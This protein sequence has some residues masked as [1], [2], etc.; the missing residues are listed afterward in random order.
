MT[1]LRHIESSDYYQGNHKENTNNFKTD[2]EN[3]KCLVPDC[4]QTHKNKGIKGSQNLGLFKKF[5]EMNISD[6]RAQVVATKSF[7]NCLTPDCASKNCKSKSTCKHCKKTH[8]SLICSESKEN[9]KG[10]NTKKDKEKKP[11]QKE[12]EGESEVH[13][14][15]TENV[16]DDIEE[17][18]VSNMGRVYELSTSE[19][20]FMSQQD[21][22]SMN[23][24]C[25]G[26]VKVR[27]TITKEIVQTMMDI[28]SS[29]S[30]I[31]VSHAKKLGAKQVGV[32]NGL[33]F[34]LLLF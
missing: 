17:I 5:K 30:W 23:L 11:N 27:G 3:R 14:T 22:V 20:F 31:V 10:A 29:D 9:E 7:W 18:T 25:V 19:I 28:C 21:K 12:S 8:N 15:E 2:V 13:K 16:S 1:T 33:A 24:T 4:N 6:K 34:T 26:S 32:F